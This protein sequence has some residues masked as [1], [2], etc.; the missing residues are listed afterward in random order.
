MLDMNTGPMAESLFDP[1]VNRNLQ[2]SPQPQPAC[3]KAESLKC[4]IC[5]QIKATGLVYLRWH[6]K[7]IYF[8]P[9]GLW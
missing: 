4:V 2:P 6:A 7:N 3:M 8:K 9:I 5:K 1:S